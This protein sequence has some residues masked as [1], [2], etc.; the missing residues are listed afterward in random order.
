M[1][2]TLKVIDEVVNHTVE[3]YVKDYC[4]QVAT[5]RDGYPIFGCESGIFAKSAMNFMNF[6]YGLGLEW[7]PKDCKEQFGQWMFYSAKIPKIN[8]LLADVGINTSV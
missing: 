2:T 7:I 1:G 4:K 5:H 3:K 6:E 8:N